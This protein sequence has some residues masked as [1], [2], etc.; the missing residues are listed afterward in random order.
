MVFTANDKHIMIVLRREPHVMI[1]HRSDQLF[2]FFSRLRGVPEKCVRHGAAL[3]AEPKH[4]GSVRSLFSVNDVT[5][6]DGGVC[7]DHGRTCGDG[8]PLTGLDLDNVATANR[9]NAIAGKDFAGTP[10]NC[11]SET[12]QIFQGGKL[13]LP[14]ETQRRSSDILNDRNG[15]EAFDLYR[16]AAENRLVC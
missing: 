6:V 8:T 2:V 9:D 14:W 13:S 15:G 5:V 16:I 10:L 3:D 1:C 7:R 4:V 12:I 11:S